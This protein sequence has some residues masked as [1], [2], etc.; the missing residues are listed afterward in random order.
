MCELA[1]LR[2]TVLYGSPSAL[3]ICDDPQGIYLTLLEIGLALRHLH[4]RRLVHRG[5]GGG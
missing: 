5:G 3:P 4:S 2:H 1:S